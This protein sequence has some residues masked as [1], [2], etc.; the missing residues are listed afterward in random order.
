M[1]ALI[2]C[3]NCG[4]G[5]DEDASLHYGELGYCPKCGESFDDDE[6]DDDDCQS[7]SVCEE[8]GCE[9]DFSEEI[10]SDCFEDLYGDWP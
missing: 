5:L 10:C 8:C 9:S 7:D 3:P 6:D 1:S 2:D 4:V